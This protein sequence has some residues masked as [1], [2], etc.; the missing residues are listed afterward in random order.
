M[1][2]T[3]RGR[4]LQEAFEVYPTPRWATMRFLERW[5]V[6]FE[7]RRMRWIEIG[8]G[9]GAIVKAVN[10]FREARNL[11]PIIWTL[12][13][14]R[15]NM[16]AVLRELSG[17]V[18]IGNFV[19][20]PIGKYRP[21]TR[22]VAVGAKQHAVRRYDVAIFNPPF[23]LTMEILERAWELAEHCAMLQRQNFVGTEERHE[24]LKERVPDQYLIPQRVDFMGNGKCDSVCH[25]WWVWNTDCF[26]EVGEYRILELTDLDERRADRP[27][28]SYD[29]L[30][31]GG[32]TKTRKRRR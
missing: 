4:K 1:S 29:R 21:H 18:R 31:P 5:E 30:I 13:E 12:C 27:R 32:E 8:A 19:T 10:E 6:A 3:G 20:D 26:V 7:P 25:A 2:S 15:P 9:N 23:T 14:I 24:V 28:V 11:P 17:D 22:K 16:E